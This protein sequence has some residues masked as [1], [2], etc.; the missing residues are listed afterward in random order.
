M[1]ENSSN[2]LTKATQTLILL[3]IIFYVIYIANQLLIP[4]YLGLLI[5]VILF[6]LVRFFNQK[7]RIPNVLSAGLAILIGLG[8]LVL[9]FF[10]LSQQ[11][12]AVFRDLPEIKHNLNIHL[13]AL[14]AWMKNTFHVSLENQ[15]KLV[16]SFLT[17][18]DLLRGKSIPSIQPLTNGLLNVVLVPLYAFFILLYRQVFIGFFHKLF[19]ANSTQQKVDE[20]IE[21]SLQVI[22]QYITGLIIQMFTVAFLTGLGLY[23]VGVKQFLFLGI[24]AGIL[25]LIPYIGI[26]TSL[27][28]SILMA[29][30]GSPDLGIIIKVLV[31]FIVVQLIDGNILLPM[32]VGSKVRVNALATLLVILLGGTLAGVGGMFL[33]LPTLAILKVVFDHVDSLKPYGYLIGDGSSESSDYLSTVTSFLKSIPEKIKPLLK[34]G[35]K[36]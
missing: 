22:R 1:K 34:K 27:L 12:V 14:Q 5:A 9:L 32:I 3:G 4:L 21:N 33:A 36:K 8:L 17:D 13:H 10:V 20:I 31:T 25:N 2:S 7:L 11:F 24:L 28:V 6:P 18:K 29:L 35:G 16:E 23:I 19:P 30:V 26:W 15:V